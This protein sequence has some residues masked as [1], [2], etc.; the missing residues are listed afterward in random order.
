MSEPDFTKSLWVSIEGKIGR[1]LTFDENEWYY[2]T[3]GMYKEW[4]HNNLKN[5]SI[6]ETEWWIVNR[7][8]P[9]STNDSRNKPQ[10]SFFETI[11]S[12]LFG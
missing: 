3:S 5:W 10:K 11:F 7:Q 6:E 1:K 4:V 8:N 12:I 2:Y 9:V